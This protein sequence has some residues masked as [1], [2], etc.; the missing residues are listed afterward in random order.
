MNRHKDVSRM[1][2]SIFPSL[3]SGRIICKN[4]NIFGIMYMYEYQL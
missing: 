1:V 2:C 4:G 3:E